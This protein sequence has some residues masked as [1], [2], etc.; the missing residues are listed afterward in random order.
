MVAI[1]TPQIHLLRDACFVDP[2]TGNQSCKVLLP[3]EFVHIQERRAAYD[4]AAGLPGLQVEVTGLWAD[5]MR[6]GQVHYRW[7]GPNDTETFHMAVRIK[8]KAQVSADDLKAIV[9]ELYTNLNHGEHPDDFEPIKMELERIDGNTAFFKKQLPLRQIGNFRITG[10]VVTQ[11]NS[12]DQNNL[13]VQWAPEGQVIRFR[14]RAVEH[15]SIAEQVVHVGLANSDGWNVSTFRD[16]MDPSFGKYNLWAIKAAGKNTI[17]LQ[18]PFRHDPWDHRHPYDD[19][20]SPYAA[21]DFFSIDP[22]YSRDCW[23]QGLVGSWDKDAARKVANAE[24]WACVDKAHELGLK[25]I[26]DIALNHTGHNVTFRDL[27]EDPSEGEKVMR[28]NFSQIAVNPEQLGVIAQRLENNPYGTA[29]ELF[30]QMFAHKSW[31]APGHENGASSVFDTIAGGNGEWADTKQLNHGTF[32][33]GTVENHAPINDRVTDWMGRIVKYWVKPPASEPG[34]PKHPRGG[35][36]G[37]RFDHSSNLGTRFWEKTMTEV[38]AS[39]DKPILAI[40]EDF[41]QADKLRPYA[42]VMESGWYKDLVAKFKS[43]DVGG[44]LGIVD[45]PWFYETLRGGNHD[46]ER[47]IN[48]FEGDMMAAGRYL[49]MLDLL[50]GPSTTVMGDEFGEGK[51]VEFKHKGARP[52]VLGLAKVMQLSPANI[53]LQAAMFRAGTAKQSDPSLRTT[54]RERLYADGPEG[55]ILGMARHADDPS[56]PG[57]LVLVNLANAHERTNKFWLDG[58]TRS[59]IDPNGWYQA[60]DL[61]SKNAGANVWGEWKRGQDLLDHGVYA[62]LTP[63]QIQALKIERM[64]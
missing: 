19:L 56:V 36:D 60:R 13:G 18:P 54:L 34:A 55:N 17:R 39:V 41:N 12:N 32:N 44:V 3:D 50:G 49:S 5:S 11:P 8:N 2:K 61:M 58:V 7:H 48:L 62:K 51:K 10:R 26:L 6:S 33:W 24:F 53:D 20:G 29:E 52:P 45:S 15:E 47:V 38:Q 16:L 43:S 27:F 30:P 28:N 31:W 35:V 40:L 21:T 59:R 64:A 42:D 57:T 63:Y 37:F 46:E 4:A 23:E 1:T 22:R 14:P 9:P 25:V